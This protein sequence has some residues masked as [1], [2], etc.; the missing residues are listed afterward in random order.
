MH[1]DI[2]DLPVALAQRRNPVTMGLLWISMVTAFPTV[3]IGFEWFRGG[4]SLPQVFVCSVIS[5]ALL[6]IYAV[7]AT[8]L[9]AVSGLG[10]VAISR[11]VFNSVGQKI[12]ALNLMWMFVGWYALVA[13]LMAEGIQSIF[14]HQVQ[15]VILAPILAYAMAFNNL[16][17]FKGI[18]NFAKWFGA[19]VLV[20]WLVAMF[21]KISVQVP[22]HSVCSSQHSFWYALTTVSSFIIGFAI[23]GNEADYWKYARPR[24]QNSALPLAVALLIGEVFAPITGFLVA[25]QFSAADE[26]HA[27]GIIISYSFGKLALAGGLVL[28]AHYFSANDSNMFA[29]VCAAK[30]VKPMSGQKWVLILATLAAVVSTFLAVSG[31]AKSLEI[32]AGLNCILLP[33]PTVIALSEWMLSKAILGTNPA[34]FGVQNSTLMQSPPGSYAAVIAL[35]SS[36]AIGVATG[37]IIP[38]TE[39]LHVGI[40]S[41]QCWLSAIAIYVPLR[42]VE[43]RAFE[44][45]DVPALAE[46]NSAFALVTEEG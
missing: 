28:I 45:R 14:P 46:P 1:A 23:W 11:H 7:P 20:I 17:G 3:L 38:G 44:N 25:S 33:A 6:L 42:I 21:C 10:Y 32:I 16:F 15:L 8:Q 4:L 30:S 12:V 13:L 26:A 22:L 34:W 24:W 9:G 27:T 41:I 43:Y 2:S 37:G 35:V 18:V 19:P 40:N 39:F 5:C 36:I 29:L 31:T